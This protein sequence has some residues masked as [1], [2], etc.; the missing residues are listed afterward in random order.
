MPALIKNVAAKSDRSHGQRGNQ[1]CHPARV[2][3]RDFVRLAGEIDVKP[4][5]ETNAPTTPA[6]DDRATL[7]AA[8]PAMVFDTSSSTRIL[9][10]PFSA[11]CNA[12]V[13][14]T[15]VTSTRSTPTP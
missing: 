12:W 7:P 9:E 4:H 5:Q 6:R 1:D 3:P 11:F 13:D 10:V 2:L 8:P 15:P 14:S